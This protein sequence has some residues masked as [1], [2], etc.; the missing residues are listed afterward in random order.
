MEMERKVNFHILRSGFVVGANPCHNPAGPG[1]GQFCDIGSAHWPGTAKNPKKEAIEEKT[2]DPGH[3]ALGGYQGSS[4]LMNEILRGIHGPARAAADKDDIKEVKQDIKHIDKM[5]K[6]E[7]KQDIEVWRGGGRS[8]V[9]KLFESSGISD[10][11]G[12]REVFD[13]KG[14]LTT[15]PK[16]FSSWDPLF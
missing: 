10:E 6:Q 7:Q 1:G 15:P 9:E 5:F 13:N 8:F 14:K 3:K 2:G 11:I 4:T 12:D 16:G